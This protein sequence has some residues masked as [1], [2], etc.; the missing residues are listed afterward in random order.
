M[1][2]VNCKLCAE[3]GEQNGVNGDCSML[4]LGSLPDDLPTIG[5]GLGVVEKPTS[6]MILLLS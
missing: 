6:V 5:S 4:V 3:R 1:F 2:V